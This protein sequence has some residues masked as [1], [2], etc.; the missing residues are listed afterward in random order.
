VHPAREPADPLES[1][2]HLRPGTQ[3]SAE[4]GASAHWIAADVVAAL[5]PTGELKKL[6][7]LLSA[8]PLL[9]SAAPDEHGTAAVIEIGFG[10]RERVLDA[11]PSAPQTDD[12]AA[13]AAAVREKR[14]SRRGRSY[15]G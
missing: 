15:S 3:A 9:P 14:Q 2:D 13:E 6:D 5:Q 4:P 1:S 11:Q 12:Q 7:P 8:D 10:E